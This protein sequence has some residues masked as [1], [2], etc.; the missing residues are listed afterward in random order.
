MGTK[1]A[2]PA[3]EVTRNGAFTSTRSESLRASWPAAPG[4]YGLVRASLLSG[5]RIRWLPSC[6]CSDGNTTESRP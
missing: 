6:T 1:W 3:E 2:R 5:P 4:A